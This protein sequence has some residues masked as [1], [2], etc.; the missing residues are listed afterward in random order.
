M[1]TPALVG[2]RGCG[3]V[4]FEVSAPLLGAAWAPLSDD[5]SPRF[6]EELPRPGTP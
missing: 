1:S 3:A 4:R 2:S 6:D 5:G